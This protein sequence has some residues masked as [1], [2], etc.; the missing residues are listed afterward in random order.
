MLFYLFKVVYYIFKDIYFYFT[1][2]KGYLSLVAILFSSNILN[3][4][5]LLYG[6]IHIL[7]ALIFFTF[8]T[9]AFVQLGQIN[10]L[11]FKKVSTSSDIFRFTK[12]HTEML[13]LIFAFDC[14][15][16]P[17]LFAFMVCQVP[18]NTYLLTKLLLGQFNRQAGVVF[19]NF[20]SMQFVAI[21]FFHVL[22]AYYV[23]KI[24]VHQK[25]FFHI[26]SQKRNNNVSLKALF[27]VNI[28]ISKFAITKHRYG[29]TY[30]NFDLMSFSSFSK[31]TIFYTEFILYWFKLVKL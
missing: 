27:G 13:L 16:G 22:G 6:T 18:V 23:T 17:G 19:L 5:V 26:S 11:L 29:L 25:R 24:H 30:N 12:L 2:I 28:Y 20:I 8:T 1:T 10:N 7:W 9:T 4:F 21:V 3:G 31:F 14:F 15:Y